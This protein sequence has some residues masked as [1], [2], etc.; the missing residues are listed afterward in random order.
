MRFWPAIV[1][2]E[3]TVGHKVH[4]KKNDVKAAISFSQPIRQIATMLVVCGI[5]VFGSWVIKTQ[6]EQ[7]MRTNPLLNLFIAGVFAFGVLA[8][9][10]QVLILMQSVV[11]IEN[12]ANEMPGTD[13]AKPPRL[14]APLAALLRSRGSKMQITST[15][16][17]SILDSVE[18]GRAHV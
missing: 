5:V 18:I 7:I 6:V 12:F 2:S 9:F 10:W 15:S 3:Q 1:A 11:W 8:C 17:N 16:A 13:E 14:L 4:M